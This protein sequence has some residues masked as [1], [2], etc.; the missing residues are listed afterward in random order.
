MNVQLLLDNL[1]EQEQQ[2]AAEAEKLRGRIEELTG[3]IGELDRQLEEL[4]ITRKTRDGLAGEIAHLE[5]GLP[6]NPAYQQVLKRFVEL[7]LF[8]ETEP[9]PFAHHPRETSI[10]PRTAHLTQ[11]N[12]RNGHQ[13]T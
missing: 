9:R 2:I 5:S 6:N 12:T 3:Q 11:A 7:G 1:A 4:K 10:T 8:A 13:P